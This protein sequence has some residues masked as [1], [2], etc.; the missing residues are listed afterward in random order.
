KTIVVINKDPEAPLFEIADFGVVGDLFT[1]LPA[2]TEGVKA[3][4]A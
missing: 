2:A 4:K 1:V 3:R